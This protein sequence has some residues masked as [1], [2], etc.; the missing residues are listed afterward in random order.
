MQELAAVIRQEEVMVR[1]EETLDNELFSQFLPEPSPGPVNKASGEVDVDRSRK[2]GSSLIAE[3]EVITKKKRALA[4]LP[5]LAALDGGNAPTS[6]KKTLVTRE[7][8]RAGIKDP[9]GL[10]DLGGPSTNA[11]E[12]T[13]TLELLKCAGYRLD[14]EGKKTSFLDKLDAAKHTQD[15]GLG[16]QS[17]RDTLLFGATVMSSQGFLSQKNISDIENNRTV[18][19]TT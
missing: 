3:L 16:A 4:A 9:R 7:K 1:R 5:D 8:L 15:V 13:K 18:G 17:L 12:R 2:R 10:L 11:L 6:K 19:N 14:N